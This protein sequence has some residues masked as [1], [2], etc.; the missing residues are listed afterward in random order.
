MSRYRS[1][2]SRSQHVRKLG[3][4][5]YVISWT[6]DFYYPT[7][8]LRHPRTFRRNTDLAGAKRFAKRWGLN[9]ERTVAAFAED[10]P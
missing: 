4:D 10:Q 3:P 5:W 6:V 2:G 9:D 7:S 8:R 1:E